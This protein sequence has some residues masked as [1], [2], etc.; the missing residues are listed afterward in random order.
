MSVTSDLPLVCPACQHL[1]QAPRY[2]IDRLRAEV[3]VRH[4]FDDARRIDSIFIPCLRWDCPG[5]C[6]HFLRIVCCLCGEDWL[7]P[8]DEGHGWRLQC[9]TCCQRAAAMN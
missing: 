8:L 7:A 6:K 9:D 1:D 2:I 5:C 3:M 4:A